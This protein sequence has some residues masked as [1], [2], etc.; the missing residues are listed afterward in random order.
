M[1]LPRISLAVK[2]RIL[3]GIAVALILGAALY[4]PWL[5]MEALAEEQPYREARRAAEDH[6]RLMHARPAGTPLAP[7]TISLEV[8]D[9]E[10]GQEAPR[11]V[12]APGDPERIDEFVAAMRDAPFVAEALRFFI[13]HPASERKYSLQWREGGRYFA[14]VQ[15]VRVR[16]SCLDCHA[17]GG[18]TLALHENQLAGMILVNLPFAAGDQQLVFNRLVITA[19]GLLAGIFAILVFYVIT[20]R[21]ILAPIEELRSVAGR[22]AGGDLDSRA[23]IDTGDEFEQLARS[24]NEML[25][26]LRSQQQEL[27]RAN[28]L[29]DTK[30]EEMAAANVTL[31]ESNRVKSEF[32]ANVSHEL[33]TPLTSIIGF[34]ELLREG[35]SLDPNTK[36]ARYAENILI[37]GRILLEIINDLLDLAKIEA[38]RVALHIEEFD[39]AQLAGTLIDFMRPQADK[40]KL[41]LILE[42]ETPLPAMQSDPGRV[43]QVLFNLLSNAVKFTPE[44]G[45]VELRLHRA[46]DAH[47]RIEVVDTGPGISPENQKLIFEKFRQVD[48]SATREHHGTGLGLAIARELAELMGG[49]IGVKSEPGAGATFWVVLPTHAPEAVSRQVSLI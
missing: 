4:V 47:V 22:V 12:P 17:G 6:F 32:L 19:A 24:V 16:K 39:L 28:A 3:F 20:H 9:Q 13:R 7:S 30:L 31:Y 10:R 41:E 46:D 25:E 15:A 29:L 35:P 11:Y 48:Q 18:A 26:Q 27:R 43:R 34:A 33:R 45:R 38:G 42:A 49:R 40:N 14:Y 21:F 44:G 36:Q 23:R 5:R 1:R 8:S 37:S 2:Y